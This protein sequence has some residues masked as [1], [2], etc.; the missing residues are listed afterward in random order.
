M[1]KKDQ[2]IVSRLRSMGMRQGAIADLIDISAPAFSQAI[3]R[4]KDYLDERTL[5]VLKKGLVD[6]G[7]LKQADAL[8]EFIVSTVHADTV[9]EDG[10]KRKTKGGNGLYENLIMDERGSKFIWVIPE[11]SL[12]VLDE[13]NALIVLM[14]MHPDKRL[15][16]ITRTGWGEYVHRPLS[17]ELLK[18]YGGQQLFMD[19]REPTII[20]C[21]SN[22]DDL[23]I[24][25]LYTLE[26]E[27]VQV[28]AARGFIPLDEASQITVRR[29]L[30]HK[31]GHL[32][33]Q[34][35]ASN[36]NAF[37]T[38]VWSVAC[39]PYLAAWWEIK[40]NFEE[41]EKLSES[42]NPPLKNKIA[43]LM[44]VLNK[45]FFSLQSANTYEGDHIN[46]RGLLKKAD[47]DLNDD[48]EGELLNTYCGYEIINVIRH[49]MKKLSLSD[50][51]HYVDGVLLYLMIRLKT[52]QDT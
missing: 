41:L 39:V 20:V 43:D 52:K 26:S 33:R 13:L 15:F 34:L 2:L 32:L 42:D 6:A 29:A 25:L 19:K 27:E 16:I 50:L 3:K 46:W 44:R 8:S 18:G 45:I 14:N 36:L 7:L 4:E 23:V 51:E 31:A 11:P 47:I 37:V 17:Q 1:S 22:L 5:V 38:P 9:I 49:V 40:S 12:R 35:P 10:G 48:E 30:M 28:Y 24:E 21:E